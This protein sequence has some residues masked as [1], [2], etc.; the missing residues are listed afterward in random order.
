MKKSQNA[1]I[2]TIMITGDHKITALAIAKQIGLSENSEAVTR[3]KLEEMDDKELKI[4]LKP[5]IYL[6]EQLLNIN[7]ESLKI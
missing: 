7:C 3:V 4:D 1:G 2:R 5:L 6:L